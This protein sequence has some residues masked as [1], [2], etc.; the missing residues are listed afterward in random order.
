MQLHTYLC[1]IL[2]KCIHGCVVNTTCVQNMRLHAY[3]CGRSC[4]CI[5]A[6]DPH[7]RLGARDLTM[8]WG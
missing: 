7:G 6:C 4:K 3:V 2:C 5:H 1:D 8:V